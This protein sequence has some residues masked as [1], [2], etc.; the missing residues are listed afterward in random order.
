MDFVFY[1]DPDLQFEKFR[2]EFTAPVGTY[3]EPDEEY[4]P[5]VHENLFSD[6]LGHYHIESTYPAVPVIGTVIGA[7]VTTSVC[8]GNI[9]SPS[10]LLSE[11]VLLV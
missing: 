6:R 4:Y 1:L 2:I 3:F 8:D 5:N 7:K 9:E 11:R 10:L